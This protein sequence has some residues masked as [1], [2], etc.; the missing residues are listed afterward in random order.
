MGK[1]RTEGVKVMVHYPNNRKAIEKSFGKWVGNW[2]A[3]LLES[4]NEGKI[5]TI[6]FEILNDEEFLKCFG[7]TKEELKHLKDG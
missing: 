5:H 4:I 6:A 1:N 3:N 7:N 2:Y